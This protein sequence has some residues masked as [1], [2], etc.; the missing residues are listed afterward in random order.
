VKAAG[1]PVANARVSLWEMADAHTRIE[2]NGF[3]SRLHPDSEDTT[4]TDE[5]GFF[6]L[7][8]TRPGGD[9]H[10][11][12]F[13]RDPKE[14]RTFAI[15]C[16][17][18]GWS[19]AEVSPLDIDPAVG[20]DGIQIAL[21]K[22]G[23]LEG[24][25]LTAP[26]K[27]PAGVVVGL[28]RTD[29]KPRTLRVGPDGRF[30]FDHLTPGRYRLARADAEFSPDHMSTSWSNGPDV[31]AEYP[32]NCSVDEGRAT[33]FDLDL[34][35]DQPCVL[36]AQVSVNGVPATGWTASLRP[37][38]IATT[39]KIPGGAVDGQGRLRIEAPEAGPRRLVLEPPAQTSDTAQFEI[40]VDLHRGE[41]PLPV[42]LS[43]GSIR[44]HCS[45]SPADSVLQF[46]TEAPSGP[47]FRA[48][49]HLDANGRFEMPCVPAGPGR[50][51][52]NTVQPDGGTWGPVAQVHADVP[53]GGS[54]DVEVP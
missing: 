43:V 17:A 31:H 20:V 4:T 7:D 6:Q 13:H 34:R 50:I 11:S 26:G 45:A 37:S 53:R 47:V 23:A 25:V 48:L 9:D 10:E 54:V 36:V 41:N 12:F 52:R 44:G 30:R 49:V 1:E 2:K 24:K 40:P 39:Q 5:Q 28:D 21:V 46:S 29:G 3:V 35:D 22:G 15:L 18:E 8:P 51:G 19:L 32:T 14:P 38:E 33:K 16:E 27:E 42:D